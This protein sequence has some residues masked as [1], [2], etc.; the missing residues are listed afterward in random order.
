MA[1]QIGY[2]CI[3]KWLSEEAPQL[4]GVTWSV[5]CV[6][7]LCQW[8]Y[9]MLPPRQGSCIY[10]STIASL[11]FLA[12]VWLGPFGIHRFVLIGN[13]Q[14]CLV[15]H[16]T[17]ID[18]CWLQGYLWVMHAL[19]LEGTPCRGVHGPLSTWSPRVVSP[20]VPG[21]TSLQSWGAV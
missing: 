11:S 13:S 6:P 1:R 14:W 4:W 17:C 19:D 5:Q 8:L 10:Q 12:C 2:V 3:A 21:K 9:K 16:L 20:N 18:A 15:V 7:F